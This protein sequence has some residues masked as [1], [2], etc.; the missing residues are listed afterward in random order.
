V[1]EDETGTAILTG[2]MAKLD[3]ANTTGHYSEQITL[4]AANGFEKGK[5]YNIY[6]TAAVSSVTGAT[7]RNFQIE[8]EVDANVVSPTVSANMTQI[9]GSSSA[10]D[11][12]EEGALTLVTGAAVTGTLSTTQMTTDLTEATDNHYNGRLLTFRGGALDG[13]QTDITDYDG[14]TKLLTFTALTESP[15][16]GQAFVIS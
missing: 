7:V 9:S 1:Y 13:Q 14:S 6:V 4:S 11:K 12:L 3:D 8:A 2:S 5:S 10:A 16:N 15:G